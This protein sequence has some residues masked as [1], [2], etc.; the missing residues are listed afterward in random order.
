MIKK[1]MLTVVTVGLL[2][3]S[4]QARSLRDVLPGLYGPPIGSTELDLSDKGITE[5]TQEEMEALAKYY[6]GLLRLE[7]GENNLSGLPSSIGNLKKL[8]FLNISTNNLTELPKSIGNLTS[9]RIIH[10]F[11]NLLTSLPESIGNLKNL[12]ALHIGINQLDTLPQSIRKLTE[13][14]YLD[15]RNNKLTTLS[16]L[17]GGLRKLDEINVHHGQLS[18]QEISRIKAALP[19]IKINSVPYNWGSWG[20]RHLTMRRM[21]QM[22]G[23]RRRSRA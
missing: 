6:P 7:L 19:H 9:L 23:K 5:I 18:E 4:L 8:T 2:L 14:Q 11:D 1:I 21:R 22:S 20:F 12:K 17:I 10:L 16:E 3:G 13:L 15:V